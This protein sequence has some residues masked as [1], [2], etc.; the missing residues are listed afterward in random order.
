MT[1]T[2]I[3]VRTLDSKVPRP[4]PGSYN[5]PSDF[6]SAPSYSIKHR[7]KQ[8]EPE[9]LPGYQNLGTTIGE[10]R[11]SA[12]HSRPKDRDYTQSPGPNYVP[13]KLGSDGKK[14]TFH[15]R[16]NRVNHESTP[17]PGSYNIA[18]KFDGKQFTIKSRKW[19]HEE[20]EIPGP[21]V[22]A[23]YP[24]YSKT[25]RASTA[26]SIRPRFEKN[27]KEKRPAPGDYNISRDLSKRTSTLHQKHKELLPEKT[28]GPLLGPPQFG[29][30]GKKHTIR[31]R[32][33]VKTERPDPEI[34]TL[35]SPF[36]QSRASTMHSKSRDRDYTQ[37]PGPF[38]MPPPFGSDAR[39]ST[40][41]SRITTK[42]H[43][44]R[45]PPGPGKYNPVPVTTTRSYSIASKADVP[46]PGPPDTPGPG[47]YSPDYDVEMKSSVKTVIL[48]RHDPKDDGPGAPYQELGSTLGGPKFTIGRKEEVPVNDGEQ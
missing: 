25:M 40:L 34:L 10:G 30:D 20:G 1:S 12:M 3:L 27:D 47:A 21:G 22:G 41:K 16:I 28:P 31:G 38:Y 13:P 19:I 9:K 37:S 17:G 5:I 46:K 6:G 43:T 7:Y 45:E 14:C 26:A 35:K 18:T 36:G 39:K 24:D 2:S 32:I 42:R 48:G 33:D 15:E 44:E 4:G 23:L 8:K 29:E 11:K